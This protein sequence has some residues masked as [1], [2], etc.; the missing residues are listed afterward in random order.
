MDIPGALSNRPW[1]IILIQIVFIRVAQ[2]T[3]SWRM[4][5]G[6]FGVCSAKDK[7]QRLDGNFASG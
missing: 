5:A 1:Y 2:Q 4:R 3:T 7:H 6:L